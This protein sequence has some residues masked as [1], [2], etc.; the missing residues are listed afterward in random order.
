MSGE[1]MTWMWNGRRKDLSVVVGVG[2]LGV[3]VFALFIAG[4][5]AIA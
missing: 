1:L 3:A 2:V 5:V 4:L